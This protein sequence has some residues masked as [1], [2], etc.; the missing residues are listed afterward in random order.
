M[1]LDAGTWGAIIVVV[2]MLIGMIGV[3]LIRV[4]TAKSEAFIGYLLGER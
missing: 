4:E 3:C 2:M 1:K